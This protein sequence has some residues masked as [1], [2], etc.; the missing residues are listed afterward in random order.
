MTHA[1]KLERWLADLAW[2]LSGALQRWSAKH[3]K[4]VQ[5]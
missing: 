5:P 3:S 2:W 4:R 1:R